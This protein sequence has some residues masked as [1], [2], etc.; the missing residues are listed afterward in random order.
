MLYHADTISEKERLESA[1][2]YWADFDPAE[3]LRI[4]LAV[5]DIKRRLARIERPLSRSVDE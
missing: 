3:S 5:A 4:E 1:L 2:A